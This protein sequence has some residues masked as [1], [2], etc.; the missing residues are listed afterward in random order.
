L[1]SISS[2]SGPRIGNKVLVLDYGFKG[3]TLELQ[4]DLKLMYFKTAIDVNDLL[5]TLV[6]L[7]TIQGD[8]ETGSAVRL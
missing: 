8:P 5:G 4:V 3:D 1:F 2:L 7:A 6:P